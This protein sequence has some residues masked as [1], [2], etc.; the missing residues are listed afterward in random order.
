[1][2]N[3]CDWLD[4]KIKMSVWRS[5]SRD[6]SASECAPYPLCTLF[7]YCRVLIRLRH[8]SRRYSID[9]D[10]FGG[11]GGGGAEEDEEMVGTFDVS[12]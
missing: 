1:M 9:E 2:D 5:A 7:R 6:Q 10:W 11:R 12:E 4:A 8:S 3:Q